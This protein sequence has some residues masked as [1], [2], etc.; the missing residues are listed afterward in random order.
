MATVI[1]ND[2][3]DKLNQSLQFLTQQNYDRKRLRNIMGLNEEEW[4]AQNP[5][6][7]K[8][9]EMKALQQLQQLQ[10]TASQDQGAILADLKVTNPDQYNYMIKQE[11]D[12]KA[13][14][15]AENRAAD[16]WAS[17]FFNPKPGVIPE[18]ANSNDYVASLK[19][20]K[21]QGKYFDQ[22]SGSYKTALN[23]HND[24]SE[25]VVKA[26]REASV[27]N[28]NAEEFNKNR[29]KSLTG[30]EVDQQ[31]TLLNE[32]MKAVKA[33]GG[34]EAYNQYLTTQK[35]IDDHYQ[36]NSRAL[37]PS[38]FGI[39]VSG[40]KGD[41]KPKE[42]YLF[43]KST[44]KKITGGLATDKELSSS[45]PD[46]TLFKKY[47]STMDRLGYTD[48]SNIEFRYGSPENTG[49]LDDNQK[50]DAQKKILE[51]NMVEKSLLEKDLESVNTWGYQTDEELNRRKKS[52]LV[53]KGYAAQGWKL[54]QYGNPYKSGSGNSSTSGTASTSDASSFLKGNK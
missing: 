48:I 11:A 6:A 16:K 46:A 37:P 52:L 51:N 38:A 9:K 41:G 2:S 3:M 44:G 42:V 12:K 8:D 30:N 5:F 28:K 20:L 26:N 34:M 31:Q 35:A 53:E 40:S 39:G 33:G 32:T 36:H 24:S 14:D 13:R 21:D 15:M 47:K 27:Y 54:D 18:M 50:A 17:E 25:A 1:R 10:T 7:G 23:K 49:E 45:D 29:V 4:E 43:D 22:L 19:Q